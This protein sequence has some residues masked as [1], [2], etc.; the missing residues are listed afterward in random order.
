MICCQKNF[1]MVCEVIVAS[2][3]ASIQ[4]V[5]YSMATT[6]YQRFLG[7]VGRSPTKSIAHR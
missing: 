1:L 3:F 6:P 7:A 2:G 5:K 4:M